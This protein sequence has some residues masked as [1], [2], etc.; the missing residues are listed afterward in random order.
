MG[1]ELLMVRKYIWLVV[2]FILIIGTA[3]FSYTFLSNAQQAT[4][5][6][7]I[8]N[9]WWNVTEINGKK[10]ENPERFRLLFDDMGKVGGKSGCNNFGGGY[11]LQGDSFK[12]IPP[13]MGTK[14]ACFP[15]T[16][17]QDESTFFEVMEKINDLEVIDE[18]NIVL[19]GDEGKSLHLTRE[20]GAAE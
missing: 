20:V 7:D 17:M 11:M 18:N 2:A 6:L 15:E 1:R 19:K 5:N 9:I 3:T 10:I 8:K 13:F 4:D 14:M 16:V 12:T